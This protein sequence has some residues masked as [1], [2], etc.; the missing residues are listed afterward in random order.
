VGIERSAKR[1]RRDN[2]IAS[3]HRREQAW[4]GEIVTRQ[5]GDPIPED[6]PAAPV[7]GVRSGP[8]AGS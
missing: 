3:R 5:V 2:R 4:G 6:R 7:P 1:K 8:V